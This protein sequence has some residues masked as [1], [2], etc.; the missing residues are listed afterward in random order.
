M[1][2]E[3]ISFQVRAACRN[4]WDSA[5]ELAWRTFLRFE[6]PIYTQEGVRNFREFVTNES[7]YQMFLMGSYQMFSAFVGEKMAGMITL[8]GAGHISLLFVEEC[9]HRHGI[10]KALVH[11]MA[12]YL[13][14][15]MGMERMTVNAS[16]YGV[17]FYHRLGF[18]DLAPEMEKDGI[19]YTPMELLF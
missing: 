7:L 6:A 11:V 19:R 15:E 10:G 2:E 14:K 8:R 4:D 9:Y 18:T 12:E 17:G 3:E 5:M 16:P 13:Q 1:K